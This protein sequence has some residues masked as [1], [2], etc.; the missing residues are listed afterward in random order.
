MSTYQHKK[1][2]PSAVEKSKQ[3]FRNALGTGFHMIEELSSSTPSSEPAG[4]TPE[5]EVSKS[6]PE[7]STKIRKPNS[8]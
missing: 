1:Q 4:S 6:T 3:R 5:E 2:D 8:I 7:S